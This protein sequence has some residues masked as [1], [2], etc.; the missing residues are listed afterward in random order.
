MANVQTSEVHAKHTAVNVEP[1]KVKADNNANHSIIMWYLNPIN[2]IN[3]C[4]RNLTHCLT[5][6]TKE[7]RL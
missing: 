2:P 6:V 7:I 3:N 1:W 5:K 4:P